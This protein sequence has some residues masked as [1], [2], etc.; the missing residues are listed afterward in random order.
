MLIHPNTQHL[1]LLETD[2]DTYPLNEKLQ[3]QEMMKKTS[4]DPD[5][6]MEDGTT[7]SANESLGEFTK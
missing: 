4:D 3:V 2:N 6:K 5:I 7:S 1:L